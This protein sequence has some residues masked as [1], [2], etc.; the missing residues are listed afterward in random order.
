MEKRKFVLYVEESNHPFSKDLKNLYLVE[1]GEV[2]LKKKDGVESDPY[3]GE[4]N[5]NGWS[6]IQGFKSCLTHLGLLGVFITEELSE[7]TT[8]KMVNH[9]TKQ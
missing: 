3:I 6:Y 5:H 4:I 9:Y 1:N 2:I 8:F 7:G